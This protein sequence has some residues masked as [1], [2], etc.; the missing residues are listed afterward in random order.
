[1]KKGYRVVLHLRRKLREFFGTKSSRVSTF[2]TFFRRAN[3][4][5]KV[6]KKINNSVCQYGIFLTSDLRTT[7]FLRKLCESGPRDPWGFC[8]ALTGFPWKKFD[9]THHIYCC[10]SGYI[11]NKNSSYIGPT[12]A[13]K[14]LWKIAVTV[15]LGWNYE[16]QICCSIRAS[17][18]KK[19]TLKNPC[20]TLYVC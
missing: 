7:S 12:F 10:S 1:M 4:R 3:L 17:W 20:R 19:K 5:K 8:A 6:K 14:R 9:T 15:I 16:G 11:F 13:L 2:L 18:R